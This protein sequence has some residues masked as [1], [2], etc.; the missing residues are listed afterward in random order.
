MSPRYVAIIGSFLVERSAPPVSP[1]ANCF[2]FVCRHTE[3][4]I[5]NL[6]SDA[7]MHPDP[8]SLPPEASED[9]GRS[10]SELI[11]HKHAF[12]FEYSITRQ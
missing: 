4:D 11:K 8:D 5:I 12:F 9:N 3:T 10:E 2:C 6:C 1:A 7:I